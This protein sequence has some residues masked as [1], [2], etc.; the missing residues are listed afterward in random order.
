MAIRD[1]L[2]VPHPVLKQV[3]TGVE[4]CFSTGCGTVRISRIAMEFR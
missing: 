4:T 1:I 3:S 2:T